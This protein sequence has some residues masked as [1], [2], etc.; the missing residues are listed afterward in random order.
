MSNGP[1]MGRRQ[2]PKSGAMHIETIRHKHGDRVYVSYLLRQT[3]REDG[4]I[5]HRT[6]AN[7]TGV[8]L[9]IIELIRSS[10]RGEPVA[11]G[12]DEIRCVRSRSHGAVWAVT[13]MMKKLGLPALLGAR[14]AP[15]QRIVLGMITARVLAAGSKL[16]ATRWWKT[17]TLAEDWR[18]PVD[19]DEAVERHRA[20][21]ELYRAL[22][23]L[24]NRQRLIE[25]QLAARHLRQG[26]LVLFDL[27]SSYVEGRKCPLAAF[28][29]NRDG[30]RGKQQITYGLLTTRE[31]CPVAIEVFA[32]NQSDP[33]SLK[34]QID[35]LRSQ[36]G[37]TDLV[38][39]GD[40][41]MITKTRITDLEAAGL[42]WLTSLRATDIQKLHQQGVL[43]LSLFDQ[44]DLVELHDPEQPGRRLVACRNPLLAADRARKRTEL[45]ADT[46]SELDK[47]AVRVQAG[48]LKQAS[49]IGVAVGKV[50]NRRKVAKHFRITIDEGVFT[51][52]RDSASIEREAALDGVYIVTTNVPEEKL[53]ADGAVAGY[54]SLRNV[55]QAFRTMKTT[56]LELR[57]IFHRLEDRVRAHAFLCMLAYYVVW[58]MRQALEPLLTEAEGFTSLQAL[59][60]NLG[61]IERHTMEVRGYQFELVTE[62]DELQKRILALLDVPIPA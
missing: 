25:G 29:H 15:W 39:V 54:K 24:L 55:E 49:A 56:L 7:L 28:G 8:P 19:E 57:P 32:G 43:Q 2:K 46:E 53:S 30:K 13:A 36:Y 31:G 3:Y 35:R 16:F 17:T 14:P 60:N 22:D 4:K 5:K 33:T 9:P 34:P 47:I 18:L 48:R 21:N 51:Y 59:L 6:I 41:G 50:I 12:R 45:L 1:R 62:P 38:V 40:R 52:E 26:A 44:R 37:F 11:V 42:D 61:T 23:A 27:S 20:V 58:H 10:L